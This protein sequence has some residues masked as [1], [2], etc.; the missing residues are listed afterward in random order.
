MTRVLLLGLGIL[1]RVA[2]KKAE[3][4]DRDG[5]GVEAGE[6]CDDTNPE[7]YP[8]RSEIPYD[9]VDNDCDPSTPDDD[10]DGDGLSPPADCND[11]DPDIRPGL[12][13]RPYDGIDQDCDDVTPDDDLDGDGY[14]G[15]EDCNDTAAGINPGMP[16]I[17]YD[18]IDNDCDPLN[19]PDDDQDHDGVGVDDDCD[20]LDPLR[21]AGLIYYMDCDADGFA[22]ST[23][24]AVQACALPAPDASCPDGT[25]TLVEP[26]G[27][28]F[29]ATNTTVDCGDDDPDAFPGQ[30][31][32]F[33]TQT[34][35]LPPGSTYDYDCSGTHETEHPVYSCSIQP[36]T[37]PGTNVCVF[38]DGFDT[39]V[40]CGVVGTMRTGCVEVSDTECQPALE[41]FEVRACH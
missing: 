21:R 11:M 7:V 10:L 5:D 24:G 31:A 17:Y 20:D 35:A 16:E 28:A 37:T 26:V 33:E 1:G 12:P 4:R 27:P 36:S 38:E 13:E 30:D 15:L 6:D 25:W 22:P 29:D 39:D 40:A 9:G 19:T 3:Y 34:I 2:C 23:D 32:W 41:T 18:D 14:D 8:N